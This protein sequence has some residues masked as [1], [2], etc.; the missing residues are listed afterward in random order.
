MYQSIAT[1]VSILTLCVFIIS[2]CTALPSGG[3]EVTASS[4]AA[5]N[6]QAGA[7]HAVVNVTPEIIHV[8]EKSQPEA[9]LGGFRGPGAS[10]IRIGVGD[11]V[12]VT[13]FEASPGGLFIP[14]ES[15]NSAGNFVNLPD[16]KVDSAGNIS[17]PYAGSVHAAGQEPAAVQRV[18]E[19]RLASRAIEPQAVVA[20]KSQTSSEISV[21]GDVN[22]PSKFQIN[23]NGERVLDVIARAGGPKQPGYETYVTLQRG[24]R[25]ATVYFQ[26]LVREPSNNIHVLPGDTIYVYR[27]AHSFTAFG[28]SNENGRYEFSDETINLADALGKAGGLHDNRANPGAVL[29]YRIEDRKTARKLGV[30]VD[31]FEGDEIPVIYQF[32]L[33]D[34]GG[35]FL[36]SSFPVRNKDVL[37][38]G[39]AAIVKYLKFIEVVGATTV[40]VSAG[41]N[42]VD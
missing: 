28:A 32:N 9:G 19:Q 14:L 30:P 22:S 24:K 29:I 39:N 3:P 2:G 4:Y 26:R 11:V 35:F 25:K 20:V 37:Y 5:V 38:I 13:I 18:I 16:Q 1:P 12:G 21:L 31:K 7:P 17:V 40:A 10:S 34:P 15:T 41:R 23:S 33:R 36:A 42:V 8:V 27:E 6:P